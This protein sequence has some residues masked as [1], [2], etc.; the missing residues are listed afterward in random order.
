MPDSS[1]LATIKNI[2]QN[3]VFIIL[4]VLALNYNT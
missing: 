1:P 3:I 2:D 4:Q